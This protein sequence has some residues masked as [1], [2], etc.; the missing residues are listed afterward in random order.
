MFACL[1]LQ[2]AGRGSHLGAAVGL[3]AGGVDLR[4]GVYHPLSHPQVSGL[5]GGDE[6]C[7]VILM[8][9]SFSALSL[10]RHNPHTMY[11]SDNRY[12]PL[13]P[14]LSYMHTHVPAVLN[15]DFHQ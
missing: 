12:A 9:A 4:L 2:P 3:L 6:L 10:P 14:H 11:I 13:P 1:S 8:Y 15:L 7:A 5:W